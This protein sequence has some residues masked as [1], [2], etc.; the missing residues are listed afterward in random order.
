MSG[1]RIDVFLTADALLTINARAVQSL[2]NNRC[3]CCMSQGPCGGSSE[4]RID[5]A[6]KVEIAV[7]A[8]AGKLDKI[9]G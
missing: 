3:P 8:A 4:G 7:L 6:A 9:S 1:G 2:G 5:Q